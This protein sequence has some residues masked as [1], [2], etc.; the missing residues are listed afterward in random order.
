MRTNRRV[1]LAISSSRQIGLSHV[2]RSACRDPGKLATDGEERLHAS[3][4]AVAALAAWTEESKCNSAAEL[5]ED[6][7]TA[8][9]PTPLR[10]KRESA[11]MEALQRAVLRTTTHTA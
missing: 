1:M 4:D 2:Q 8:L 5:Q 10:A 9:T 6:S 7:M 11:M 3:D